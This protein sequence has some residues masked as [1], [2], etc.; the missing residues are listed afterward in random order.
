MKCRELKKLEAFFPRA[1]MSWRV[2]VLISYRKLRALL[3]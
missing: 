3:C 2:L 1:W